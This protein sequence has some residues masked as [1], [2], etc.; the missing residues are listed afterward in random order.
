MI[1][2]V[3]LLLKMVVEDKVVVLVVLVEQIFQIFLR[4]FL[5][6]LEVVEDQEIEAQ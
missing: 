2:L 1:T 3:M 5:E 6:I 4:I